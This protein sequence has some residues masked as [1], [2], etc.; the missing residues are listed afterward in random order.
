MRL[1]R[2]KRA[3]AQTPPVTDEYAVA[4]F[5]G[6]NLEITRVPGFRSQSLAP[7]QALRFRRAPRAN[8]NP[9]DD[10]L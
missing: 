1:K 4:H 3:I 7:P 8:T 5:A 6:C 2:A 10:E 9:I